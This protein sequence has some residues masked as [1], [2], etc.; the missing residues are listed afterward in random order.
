MIFKRNHILLTEVVKSNGSKGPGRRWR[1]KE[2]TASCLLRSPFHGYKN[3]V[4]ITIDNDIK[5]DIQQT[6]TLFA[7][8]CHFLLIVLHS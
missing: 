3:F 8:S 7:N 4:I 5:L 2:E 1:A 6:N